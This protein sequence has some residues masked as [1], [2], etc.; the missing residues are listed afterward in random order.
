MHWAQVQTYMGLAGLERCL[1]LAVCKDSDAIYEEWVKFDKKVF[2][3]AMERAK[4][5]ISATEPPPKLSD[6]P[7]YY[8]CQRCDARDLCHPDELGE[9]PRVAQVNCR[10]CAYAT[11]ELEGEG[12]RWSCARTGDDLSLAE[13]AKG[14]PE[15]LF[16]PPLVPWAEP[17]DAGDGYVL[18]QLRRKGDPLNL[19]A[20]VPTARFANVGQTAIAPVDAPQL[21]S[22]ALATATPATVMGEHDG[23]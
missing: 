8:E 17:I 13:Q 18:Y 1:Y 22:R 12:A 23:E 6:D 19:Y 20:H 14:C 15:H 5:V 10:T 3:W 21:D 11:P 4:R 9:P 7:L 2:E 16:I